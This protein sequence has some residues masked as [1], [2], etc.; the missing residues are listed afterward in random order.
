M[1]VAIAAVVVG[2]CALSVSFYQTL[3]MR[4]Q[5]RELREQRRAEVWPNIEFGRGYAN[6]TLRFGVQNTGI[7]PAKIETIQVLVG[8]EP[9][10]N[11][12]D[13]LEAAIGDPLWFYYQSQIGGRVLP[14]GEMI[15]AF[16]AEGELADTLSKSLSDMS[17]TL[18]YCSIYDECWRYE[19]HM[20]GDSSREEVTFCEPEEMDFE[21]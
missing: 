8:N 11:W 5:Q 19:Q 17:V 4:E 10:A 21:E 14:P 20:S 2:A 1:I 15:E 13:V 7:G 3:I 18:C 12:N 9:Q 16:L 6:K